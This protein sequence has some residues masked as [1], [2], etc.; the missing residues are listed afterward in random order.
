M[1][2]EI[3]YTMPGIQQFINELEKKG[4]LIRISERVNPDLEITEITDRISKQTDGGK[5]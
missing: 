3:K 5:A 1:L 2:K 4:E